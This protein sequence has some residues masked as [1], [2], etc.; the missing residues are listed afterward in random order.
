MSARFGP[1]DRV[2]VRTI[3]PPWHTRAPSYVRGTEGEVVEVRGEHPLPDDVVRGITPPDV[4]AVYA[5]RFRASDLW[6][7]GDHDVTVELWE[8][9]LDPAPERG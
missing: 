6:G 1:G 8:R 2:R 9:Y 7:E 4:H 5:V 3:D